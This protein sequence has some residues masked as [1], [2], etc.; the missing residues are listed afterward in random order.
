MSNWQSW[1]EAEEGRWSPNIKRVTQGPLQI[2]TPYPARAKTA[3]VENIQLIV[4]SAIPDID[5]T[6]EYVGHN[7]GTFGCLTKQAQRDALASRGTLI[8]QFNDDKGHLE[9]ILEN[10]AC[11]YK[12]TYPDLI[13]KQDVEQIAVGIVVKVVNPDREDAMVSIRFC[14]PKGAKPQTSHRPDSLYQDIKASLQYNI[15]YKTPRKTSSGAKIRVP[16]IEENQPREVLVAFNLDITKD[17]KF[18]KTPRVGDHGGSFSSLEFAH[19]TIT[20]YYES[21]TIAAQKK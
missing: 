6:L 11:I 20:E 1:L 13:R 9:T 12:F 7:S 15:N 21:R 16:D 14:P 8:S 10:M 4:D 3:N 5:D 18:G 2:P 19:N 17:G